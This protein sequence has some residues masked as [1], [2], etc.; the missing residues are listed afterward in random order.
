VRPVFRK[1]GRPAMLSLAAALESGR[2]RAPFA[3]SGV[4]RYA[5]SPLSVEVS[6]ALAEMAAL[7]MAPAAMGYTLRLLSQEREGAQALSDRVDLVWTGPEVA[8]STSRDTAVVVRELF[9]A[10][11]KS[12]L[13]S[14]FA[15]DRDEKAR[16]LF[17]PLAERMDALPELEVRMFLN[18]GRP[19]GSDAG[20]AEVLREFAE[21]FHNR[22]WPGQHYPAVFHDPRALALG[23]GPRACLHA[24]CVVVD[25]ERLLVTSANF[26]EAAHERNIEAGVVLA[27]AGAARAMRLQ[28]ESLVTAGLL[29]RVPG[30]G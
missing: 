6:A 1:L 27:D 12:V 15:M 14:S 26:T 17:Q 8:G 19:Y 2:L 7:G 13:V 25:D 21:T 28:F 22:V 3:A 20:D 24:K 4:A 30:I 16:N 9:A 23:A 18:V 5:P 10:A 29:A 11:R